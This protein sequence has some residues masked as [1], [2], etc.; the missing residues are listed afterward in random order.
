MIL[1]CG[2][3]SEPP[4]ALVASALAE[5]HA[6][7]VIL[8]QRQFANIEFA[9]SVH[10]ITSKGQLA[11]D[12]AEFKL[13]DF[14]GVYARFMD[15]RFL[16]EFKEL[17]AE[18]PLRDHCR[19]LHERLS[20]WLDLCDARVVN[21]PSAMASNGSKPFQAQLISQLGFDIPETLVTNDPELVLEFRACHKKLVYKSISGVRSI[22][23]ILDDAACR[24]LDMIRWCPVQF[25]EFVE[26]EDVR[27]HV[28]GSQVFATRISSSATDY[29]YSQ[30]QAGRPAELQE[31]ELEPEVAEK[32]VRL[33]ARLSLPFAGI[34]L[35]ITPEH[36]TYCFEV[37]PSPGFSYY[38]AHTGQQIAK[39]VAEYLTAT[40]H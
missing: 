21:R 32:C 16:P 33:S 23:Q 9:F 14:R 19:Q 1:L 8:N 4:L 24:K 3:P 27:V 13:E 37:N 34:D 15:D 12:N 38:Q 22:V 36:R 25:Q 17:P 5:L 28:V 26:G 40:P 7:A 11:I 31:C 30:Q 39:A 18:S 29:R 20:L 10:G 35:R 6:S 2:I